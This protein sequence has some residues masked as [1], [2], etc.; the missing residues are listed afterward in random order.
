MLGAKLKQKKLLEWNQNIAT[1]SEMKIK[2]LHIQYGII[3]DENRHIVTKST[4]SVSIMVYVKRVIL[5]LYQNI[6]NKIEKKDTFEM[7][8]K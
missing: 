7:K 4:I 3:W 1:K 5:K 8:L 6:R 2:L